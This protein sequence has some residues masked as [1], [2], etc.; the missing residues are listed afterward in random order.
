MRDT[1]LAATLLSVFVLLGF[2][3]WNMKDLEEMQKT[4][5]QIEHRMEDVSFVSTKHNKDLSSRW[6]MYDKILVDTRSDVARVWVRLNSDLDRIVK[7]EADMGYHEAEAPKTAEDP[8]IAIGD[9]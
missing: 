1:L 9:P 8:P 6:K 7:I 3:Y 4:V 5:T 2:V